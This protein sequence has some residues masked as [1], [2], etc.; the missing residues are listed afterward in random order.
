MHKSPTRIFAKRSIIIGGCA[1]SVTQSGPTLSDTMDCSPPGS[2]LHEILQERVLEWV[3]ISF[4]RGYPQPRKMVKYDKLFNPGAPIHLA[5][6]WCRG[7]H[8]SH[9]GL[10]QD[11]IN[12]ANIFLKGNH[13]RQ[14]FPPVMEE[15]KNQKVG[16]GSNKA[17][18][19]PE[20]VKAEMEV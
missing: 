2:S 10:N 15:L 11:N 12:T 1:C 14:F 20:P 13:C 18:T 4:S 9:S 16:M 19:I 8:M 7:G 3:A 6:N 17:A 5:S